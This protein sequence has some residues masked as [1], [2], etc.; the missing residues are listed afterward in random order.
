MSTEDPNKA[1]YPPLSLPGKTMSAWVQAAYGGPE[2]LSMETVTTPRAT[3]R[4][5]LVRPLAVGLHR[6]DVHLLRGT[7]YLIRLAYGLRRPREPIPG[8]AL[9]GQ[10][11]SV[12]PG[13]R[14]LTPGDLVFGEVTGGALA[15]WVAVD[16]RVLAPSPPSLS[17]VQAAALPVS[18]T[19]ALRA[20][21]DIGEVTKGQRVLVNG[22][23]GGVGGFAVQIARALGARVSA[24]CSAAHSNQAHALGAESV[25]D[26]AKENWT[27][28]QGSFDVVIDIVGNH[29]MEACRRALTPGG[30]Y[31]GVAGEMS[32][33]WIGPLRWLASLALASRRG[34]Q[35]FRTLPQGVRRE[36]LE[37]LAAMVEAGTLQPVVEREVPFRE[38]ARAIGRF[39]LGHARAKT[40]VRVA[41]AT[42]VSAGE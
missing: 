38:A 11:V 40:V 20:V 10:V 42:D 6:G 14:S 41:S 28:T 32:G 39:E 31:V 3:G 29:P 1:P 22:A 23:S 21:R 12:G 26:Y 37:A 35:R 36:E 18:A 19:A 24:V 15:D 27:Q 30:T 16:E 33:N 34:S 13:A 5:V 25:I 2:T 17:P 8:M 9:S 7:P 4:E